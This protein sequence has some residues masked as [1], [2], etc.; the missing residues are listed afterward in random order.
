MARLPLMGAALALV[1]SACGG[2]GGSNAGNASTP[3]LGGGDGPTRDGVVTQHTPESNVDG[4]TIAFTV[5]E[6]TTFTEGARY[7]LILHSHGYGGSRQTTRPESGGLR[8]LLD[9]GYGVISIDE[10]GHGESGGTIRILDPALEGQDLLQILDWA[11][12]NLE[13]LAYD[14]AGLDTGFGRGNPIIGAVGSSYGGGFQHLIYAIDPKHRLD[15]IAPDITWHDLRYSLFSGGVFKTFWATLLS[16]LGNAPPNTQDAQVNQGLAEGLS[17][18]MLSQENLDLLYQNSLA[19]HCNGENAFTAPGGLTPID[20]FITQSALDTLFNF[21]D[22]SNNFDCLRAQGGDVRLFTKATG[23]GIDNGDGGDQCGDIQRADATF[24]WFEE[25][26]RGVAGAADF[27]PEVCLMVGAAGNDSVT[28]SDVPLDGLTTTIDQQ[29]V[30]ASEVN[31]QPTAIPLYTAPAGG[32]VLAGIATAQLEILDPLLGADGAGDPILFL[33]L[34]VADGNG[35][36]TVFQNQYRPVRGY[37][38]FDIELNGVFA[39]L[40]EG[41]VVNLLIYPS[42]PSQY[43]T[44]ASVIPATVTVDATVGLPVLGAN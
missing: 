16:T 38:S 13:W 3:N 21:N 43:S 28:L 2:G 34:G 29:T 22:A 44:S 18:N 8:R 7:P 25:K 32:D 37:G 40:A 12:E 19:S 5:I 11:E 30:T 1:L 4:E 35:G 10:R 14:P 20:A 9:A 23:H 24:A 36:F 39:R 15:A 26:L 42:V 33:A 17:T 27:I 31:L 6:P 41:E